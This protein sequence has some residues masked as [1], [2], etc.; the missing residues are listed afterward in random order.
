VDKRFLVLGGETP[1]PVDWI[2]GESADKDL[3]AVGNGPEKC[4]CNGISIAV[5]IC[6]ETTIPGLVSN[7]VDLIV[8]PGSERSV[9]CG[10]GP[11]TML[12]NA[13]MR[14]IES[15]TP[16]V[17]VV[18]GGYTALINSSGTV[19]ASTIDKPIVGNVQIDSHFSLYSA[20]GDWL[21]PL[22]VV[23]AIVLYFRGRRL[24]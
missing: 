3:F 11:A 21:T 4:A 24:P 9:A 14:A 6:Y 2:T 17:R 8:N 19:L 12:E 7:N 22:S 5:C 13:R 1:S 10:N 18:L 16:V 20:I 23:A 15:R